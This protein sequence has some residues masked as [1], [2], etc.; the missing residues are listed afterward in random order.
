[1]LESNSI[2][3]I[4]YS[5]LNELTIFRD[6]QDFLLKL[7][8]NKDSFI[9]KKIIDQNLTFLNQRL[10]T[11]LNDM[12]LPHTVKFKS[13]LEVEIS[14]FGK[15]FDF[16]N[17]SR[18]ERTRLILSLSWTFRDVYENMNNQIN[19][20]FVDELIDGGLD[21]VGVESSLSILKNMTRISKRNIFL[22]SHKEELVSRVPNIL[23]VIKEGG[24][25]T[26]NN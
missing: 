4:D 2:Q 23:K 15:D 22:I 16:D 25:T 12:G 6:H 19:L 10:G 1:M 5:K 8:T 24:F 26:F 13:D 20:L 18:G 17:L 11:Y 3:S 14:L 21:T 9:R 7:L